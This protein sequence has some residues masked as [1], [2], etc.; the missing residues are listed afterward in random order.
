MMAT[1]GWEKALGAGTPSGDAEL[2]W[3]ERQALAAAAA[4]DGCAPG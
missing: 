2:R 4:L 1:F 3:W